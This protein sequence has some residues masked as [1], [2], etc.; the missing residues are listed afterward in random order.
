MYQENAI[1]MIKF[2]INYPSNYYYFLIQDINQ[3]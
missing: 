1:I 3:Q 2:F